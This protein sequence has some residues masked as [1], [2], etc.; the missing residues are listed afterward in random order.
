M[1]WPHAPSKIVTGPGLY[2]IT[3]GTYHK[4][5]HFSTA[6]R[7]NFL[8]D[9]L[10]STAIETEWNLEA[11]AIFSN[12]YHV[13]GRTEREHGVRELTSRLHGKTAQHINRLDN[14]SGR[15]VWYRCRDTR[16][17]HEKSYI[18]RLAYVHNNP[19][20]HLGI[21]PD[22]YPYCSYHW[23]KTKSD[24]SFFETV[25]SLKTDVVNVYDDY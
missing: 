17:T 11:W 3:A 20:K 9:A 10:F 25:M 1:T 2:I 22:N 19:L 4:E 24:R 23:F 13:V 18:A 6:D 15:K 12:H 21:H 16:I 5:H 14:E 8:Q 7:L